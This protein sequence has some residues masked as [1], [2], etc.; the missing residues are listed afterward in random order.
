MMTKAKGEMRLWLLRRLYGGFV[1]IKAKTRPRLHHSRI[2][3]GEPAEW[4]SRPP[5]W[6][7][8]EIAEQFDLFDSLRLRRGRMREVDRRSLALGRLRF[9]ENNNGKVKKT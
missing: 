2:C 9:V 7:L 5:Y 8:V 4:L 6:I 1:L 3:V